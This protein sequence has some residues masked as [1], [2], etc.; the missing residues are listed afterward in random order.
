MTRI[1]IVLTTCLILM[2]A[3]LAIVPSV[4]TDLDEVRAAVSQWITTQ[5]ITAD[6]PLPS[7]LSQLGVQSITVESFDPNASVYLQPGPDGQPGT[8]NADDNGNGIIDEASELGATRTDDVLAVTRGEVVSTGPTLVLQTGA[9]VTLSASEAP[10]EGQPWRVI[11]QGES[12]SLLID[13]P[14]QAGFSR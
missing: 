4:G 12:W 11:V 3:T 8:A 1:W 13:G 14:A 5:P 2:L 6:T 10:P 7:S 9:F